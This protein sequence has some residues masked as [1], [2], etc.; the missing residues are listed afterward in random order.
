M[1]WAG[2]WSLT[3]VSGPRGRSH[4]DRVIVAIGST[5]NG[6]G[7]RNVVLSQL[8]LQEGIVTPKEEIRTLEHTALLCLNVAPGTTPAQ[9]LT[10]FEKLAERIRVLKA[11]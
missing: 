9:L 10:G 8:R 5:A 4:P 3:A 6:K 2:R 7:G 1:E 11:G